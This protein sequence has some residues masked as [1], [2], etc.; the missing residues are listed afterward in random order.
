M[1]LAPNTQQ[2]Q[3]LYVLSQVKKRALIPKIISLILLGAVFYV[4]ILVNLFLLNLTAGDETVIKTSS[5]IL[6]ILVVILG[7]YLS[8]HKANFSYRFY[9]DRVQFGKKAI[10]YTEIKNTH[11]KKDI[12]D[13][14]FKTYAQVLSKDF[15]IRNVPNQINIAAYVQ[16]MIT[17]AQR[18]QPPQI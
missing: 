18:T 16:Q 15:Y 2:E 5:L 1:P 4:G 9:R 12:F 14:M 13:K 17:Y 8:Y 6:L 11:Q 10:K 3:P 7:I